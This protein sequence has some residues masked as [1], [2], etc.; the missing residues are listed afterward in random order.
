[1][2]MFKW[3]RETVESKIVQSNL[4]EMMPYLR[5]LSGTSDEGVAHVYLAALSYRNIYNKTAGIDLFNPQ[6]AI[7]KNK[8]IAL[9][10]GAQIRDFQRSTL[11]VSAAG[12]KMWLFTIRSVMHDELRP[13]GVALWRQF[14][15]GFPHVCAI[16][17]EVYQTTGVRNDI[18]DFGMVPMGF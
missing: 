1:M 15:R 2:A 14:P 5:E 11:Y 12:L 3:L 9:H 6:E 17:E 18:T 16:A 10:I 13:L 7:E 4:S 8:A